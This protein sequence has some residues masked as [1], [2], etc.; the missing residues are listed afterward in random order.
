MRLTALNVVA[1][2][3]S[4]ERVCT[5]RRYF[6]DSFSLQVPHDKHSAEA[7]L[8]VVVLLW[9]G[10]LTSFCSLAPLRAGQR[11]LDVKLGQ[12]TRCI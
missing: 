7:P 2:A 10:A 6:L 3:L 8:G 12:I 11:F 5:S 1:L 9:G 4:V